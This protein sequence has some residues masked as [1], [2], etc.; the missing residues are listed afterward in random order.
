MATKIDI[1]GSKSKITIISVPTFPQ[2]L[3]IEEFAT[4][5]DPLVFDEMQIA[6]TEVGVNGDV[7]TYQKPALI[8]V[9]L[10]V[11]PNS[12]SDKNLQILFNSNRSAKNKVSTKDDITMVV[13]YTDGKIVTLSGGTIMT[14]VP[15]NSITQD[16]K[17]ATKSY[18]FNF[19]N[20]I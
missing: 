5:T 2:G 11:I 9:T 7:A 19:A 20:I 16:S 10:S 6:E 13:A 18:R 15:A 4:D 3:V 14:G 17:L 8:N 1:S 12:E